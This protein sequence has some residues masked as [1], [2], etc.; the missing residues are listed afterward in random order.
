MAKYQINKYSLVKLI[1]NSWALDLNTGICYHVTLKKDGNINKSEYGFR[2][3][4]DENGNTRFYKKMSVP[5]KVLKEA[6]K[7]VRENL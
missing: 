1:N 5:L 2:I 7:Q 6:E 3:S 4:I